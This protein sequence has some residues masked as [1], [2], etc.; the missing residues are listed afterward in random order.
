MTDALTKLT[1]YLAPATTTALTHAAHTTLDTQTDTLNRAVQLYDQLATAVDG[2]A[3]IVIHW[4]DRTVDVPLATGVPP[5][6][7]TDAEFAALPV[8]DLAA[9]HRAGG[10]EQ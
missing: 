6:P 7:S 8:L 10:G 2:G 4:P 5:Y 9:F 3:R 1:A